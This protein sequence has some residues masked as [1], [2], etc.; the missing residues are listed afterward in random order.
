MWKIYYAD[1]STFSSNE[2]SLED[3]PARGVQGIAQANSAVGW[4]VASG[5]DYY[6]WC[7]DG[8]MA[9][10]IFGLF[11]YLIESGTVKFGR[12]ITNAEYNE[13]FQKALADADFGRKHGFLPEE[14]KP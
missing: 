4:H 6:I 8:W 1:G 13:I 14:R 3:A 5:G 2:G 12:T 7:D 11:D 10:D 9:V